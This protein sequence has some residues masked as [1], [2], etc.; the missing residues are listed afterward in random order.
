MISLERTYTDNNHYS[1]RWAYLDELVNS[2]DCLYDRSTH[3]SMQYCLTDNGLLMP[4]F[5]TCVDYFLCAA[6]SK[7]AKIT[8]RDYIYK[9]GIGSD[10]YYEHMQIKYS[11][12][13]GHKLLICVSFEHSIIEAIIWTAYIYYL[14]RSEISENDRWE[15]GKK[16]LYECLY[17][18]SGYDS[19]ESFLTNNWLMQKKN[20]TIIKLVKAIPEKEESQEDKD[21][22][23]LSTEVKALKQDDIKE[24]QP[25]IETPEQVQLRIRIEFL[26]KLLNISDPSVVPN[27]SALARLLAEI[28]NVDANTIYTTLNRRYGD[29]IY[30]LNKRVHGKDVGNFNKLIDDCEIEILKDFR[31]IL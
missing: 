27:K 28:L 14:F 18:M 30:T 24:E 8:I 15:K 16:V 11:E 22:A 9:F 7:Q 21:I 12:K 17:E 26:L 23:S 3:Y 2:L 29:K 25:N 4:D 20:E 31:L 1:D 6:N 19:E 10:G 5:M 13:D